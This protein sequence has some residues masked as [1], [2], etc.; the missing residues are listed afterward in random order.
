MSNVWGCSSVTEHS[1]TLS[2]RERRVEAAAERYAE[3]R[4]ILKR[5]LG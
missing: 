3:R 1:L 2:E 4:E 5:R